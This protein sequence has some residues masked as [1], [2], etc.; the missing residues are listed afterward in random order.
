MFNYLNK[1]P[2]STL[3]LVIQNVVV[4]GSLAVL[5]FG[6]CYVG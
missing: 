4:F 1:T 3:E 2:E 6:G 5:I